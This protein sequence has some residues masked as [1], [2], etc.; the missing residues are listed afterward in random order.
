MKV[1]DNGVGIPKSQL[2]SIFSLFESTKGN[3]GTGLGL[4]VSQ[5]IIHEH[6][7]EITVASIVDQGTIFTIQLPT[8]K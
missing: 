7:G 8:S 6:G 3:R 1:Q 2:K 4:P 5:K